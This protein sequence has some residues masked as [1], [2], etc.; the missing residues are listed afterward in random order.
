M[1]CVP[2]AG[3][4]LSKPALSL[5]QYV[6]CILFL[7]MAHIQLQKQNSKHSLKKLC[8]NLVASYKEASVGN[9]P[10]FCVFRIYIYITPRN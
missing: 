2:K 6:R 1:S 3:F 7:E 4:S 8:D 9:M 5:T 10:L